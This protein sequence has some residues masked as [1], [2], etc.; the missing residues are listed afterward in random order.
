MLTS[1]AIRNV[2]LIEA[3]D[4]EFGAGLSV[5]TGETGAG[6]SILLDSLGLALGA[7]ADSGL[8]RNGEAQA[9][10][11][12]TFEP[13]AADHR[14]S[15]LLADNGI[16]MEPGEPL[17]IRRLVK[18]DGGSRAFVN[19]Q[20]C[21]AALLRDLGGS[22]VEIHGQHDDRGLLNP[23]GHR[24]LLDSYGRCDAGSVAS[25][26]ADWRTAASALSQARETVETAARDRDYLTHAV[27][28]LRKFA[29]EA[30]EEATLAEERATMQKGARLT[31]DL[32]AISDCLTGSDGGLAQLRQAAR[33]LDR[34]AGEEPLLTAVLEALDR[35]VV[36]AGEAED[37]LAEAAEAL[38]F[39]P[40]RLDAIE[41]R[42]FDLRGLA[43]KHQVQPD[44]LAALCEDMAAKLAAIEGGEEHIAALEKTVAQKAAAYRTAAQALSGERQLA[45]GRLDAAVA[46]ELAPLKLDAARFRTVVAP[47]DEGQWSAQGLDRVEFEI[48]TNPGAPFAPLAKIAS[49]GELSRFILALK[50]ALA[51]RGGAD[52]LIFDEIDRGVGGA[53][54]DA[55]GE[56]LSRLAQSNQIL[57]VTH[58]PQVAARGA[59]HMLI[60]KSSDGTVTR[61]GVHALDDG[62]RREE[63][64]RMLSGA[65]ITAEA[66]AQAERLLERV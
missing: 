17:L 3:L 45:A 41:T 44:D 50:V 11:V 54:A 48:S 31:D 55:I 8:V 15:A 13:P 62:E 26:H 60:A 52:T 65:E 34:I 57:V 5:L 2:V 27:E 36:E 25:A 14:V 7:R 16:D 66:R 43:R 19:D 64:A 39:D 23:R 63:I 49:G 42:L 58:S 38:S 10:V 56:R 51:E 40:A 53:V 21:S 47:L 22:L 24:A 18:A 59:G 12:A 33:R 37:R 35:A 20:P 30:G 61:T 6:K 32:S 46:G 9:S 1:L 29:P 4:L 28:E